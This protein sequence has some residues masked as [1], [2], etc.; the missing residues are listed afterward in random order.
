MTNDKLTLKF[1]DLV[2]ECLV[3]FY[4]LNYADA[5][6]KAIELRGR[7]RESERPDEMVNPSDMIFHEEPFYVASNLMDRQLKLK[8]YRKEYTVILQKHGWHDT[9]S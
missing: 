4:G 9:P 2:V 7:L 6:Q 3:K 1:W 5:H 8:D